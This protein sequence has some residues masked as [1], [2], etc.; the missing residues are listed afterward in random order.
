[1]SDAYRIKGVI[2]SYMP[3]SLIPD[4]IR[5]MIQEMKRKIR[6]RG[7]DTNCYTFEFYLSDS[8]YYRLREPSWLFG[9]EVY[10][11]D[12][13]SPHYLSLNAR[14]NN[15][16]QLAS[17]SVGLT[18]RKDVDNRIS[19][20]SRLNAIYGIGIYN[21]SLIYNYI[22]NDINCISELAKK[23]SSKE[24]SNMFKIKNVIFSNP[25]TIVFWEDGTKTVVKCQKGD[26][27]EKE[28]GLAM[29]IAKKALGT[30][31]SK[32]NYCYV[33]EKWCNGEK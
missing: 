22:K 18:A 25:A 12:L 13:I 6:E 28:K 14:P 11:G 20:I 4:V 8:I 10:H 9:Y 24:N 2:N 29:A 26:I 32:S 21:D 7:L 1:M 31:K 33:F 30:N 19:Y 16:E 5:D 23:Y 17:H 27:Y 15:N 3:E